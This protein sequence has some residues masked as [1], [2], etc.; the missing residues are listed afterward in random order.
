VNNFSASRIPVAL[1]AL[2]SSRICSSA[3]YIDEMNDHL[4][5]TNSH[6]YD[7]T[8]YYKGKYEKMLITKK[9]LI[10]SSRV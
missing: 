4:A 8:K 1:V 5:N 6:T 7:K 10:L 2:A 3:P 9:I